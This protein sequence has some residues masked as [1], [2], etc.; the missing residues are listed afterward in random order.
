M[1]FWDGT[2]QLPEGPILS[3]MPKFHPATPSDNAGRCGSAPL[4]LVPKN[5]SVLACTIPPLGIYSALA[6]CWQELGRSGRH[7]VGQWEG[8]LAAQTKGPTKQNKRSLEGGGE[9]RKTSA[10][11]QPPHP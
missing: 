8:A 4:P 7:L 5:N 1:F 2:M 9:A 6:E 11:K 10:A 3:A